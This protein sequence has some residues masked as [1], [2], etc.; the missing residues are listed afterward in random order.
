MRRLG[1]FLIA[2]AC[3]AGLVMACTD[4]PTET[5]TVQSPAFDFTNNPDNG[6]PR[7]IRGETHWM[8]CWTGDKSELRACHSTRPH[9]GGNEPDCGL[10]EEG[11]PLS[12]QDLIFDPDDP[13]SDWIH[14][15]RTGE[16]FITVRDMNQPG[17]CLGRALVAEGWGKFHYVDN[18]ENG[19]GEGEKH[20]NAYVLRGHGV[21]ATPDGN[22]MYNGHYKGVMS[23]TQGNRDVSVKVD[24][25]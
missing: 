19:V 24:I 25:H 2:T 12:F 16:V 7:I 17:D 22:V 8:S 15:I 5:P 9:A 18:D 20:A 23:N 14:R 21:L 11:D 1:T 4:G 13:F 6:N 10:Q 3:V